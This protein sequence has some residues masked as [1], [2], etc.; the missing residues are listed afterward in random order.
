M[1]LVDVAD[2]FLLDGAG[3]AP[4]V[5]LSLDLRKPGLAVLESFVSGCV[6]EAGSFVPDLAFPFGLALWRELTGPLPGV[7]LFDSLGI[8]PRS[9]TR[10]VAFTFLRP[11]PPFP[12]RS[13]DS[14]LFGFS[15]ILPPTGCD[16][17]AA[18]AF[19]TFFFVRF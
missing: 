19:S 16:F 1:G 4:C 15:L 6:F 12:P 9:G 10:F 3:L 11:R 5:M 14:L 13:N 18:F 2:P 17:K 8:R 7:E